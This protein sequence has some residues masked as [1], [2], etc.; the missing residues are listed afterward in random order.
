MSETACPPLNEPGYRK[1]AVEILLTLLA[2]S[3][4]TSATQTASAPLSTVR[5]DLLY[6]LRESPA[7]GRLTAPERQDLDDMREFL[8]VALKSDSLRIADAGS[9]GPAH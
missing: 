8:K 6:R 7:L 1:G 5:D 2:V 9:E 3:I 4:R